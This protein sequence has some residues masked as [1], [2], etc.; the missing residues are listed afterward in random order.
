[1][2]DTW[3]SRELPILNAIHGLEET[4]TRA[5]LSGRRKKDYAD[6]SAANALAAQAAGYSD[7]DADDAAIAAAAEPLVDDSAPRP[8][9][10]RRPRAKSSPPDSYSE[11]STSKAASV[12]PPRR[13]PLTSRSTTVAPPRQF[14]RS[15]SS[16]GRGQFETS[17]HVR[18]SSV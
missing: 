14:F 7:S 4:T 10:R 13:R 16:A 11:R 3:Q 9:A 15:L 2:V 5:V 1:M 6:A 18:W 12:S 17:P 8:R